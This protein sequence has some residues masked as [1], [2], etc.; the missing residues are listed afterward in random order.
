LNPVFD[1]P[2]VTINLQASC[3]KCGCSLKKTMTLPKSM[4]EFMEGLTSVLCDPCGDAMRAE[5]DR[6]LKEQVNHER[7]SAAKIPPEFWH[8]DE[9]KGNHEVAN[10]VNLNRGIN[11][12]L[13]GKVNTCKTRAM[14]KVLQD[15]CL[16]GKKVL[17]FEFCDFAD[18]YAAKMQ[19]S[20]AS[21][22]KFLTRI[23]VNGGYDI[24][25]IDDIDK[26]RINETAGNLLYKLFNKLYSGNV[27][28][29]LWFTMNHSGKELLNRFE[30]RDYGAA[31]ISRITRMMDDGRFVVNTIQKKK[32]ITK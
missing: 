30:N 31:V 17:Y 7:L 20:V 12:L 2:Q 26:H 14:V 21:A 24:I 16:R 8:W 15:E 9:S 4:A 1:E 13:I 18:L 32:E 3:P 29:R 27:S 6:K 25:L 22:T 23:V 10:W 5:Q 11:L 28:T 19:E